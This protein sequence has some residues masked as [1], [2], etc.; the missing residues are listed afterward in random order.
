MSAPISCVR[1]RSAAAL[2]L[3]ILMPWSLYADTLLD[4][5]R[6]AQQRDPGYRVAMYALQAARERLL[7]ARAALLPMVSLNGSAGH[8]IGPTSIGGAE[9]VNRSVRNHGWNLQLTQPLWRAVNQI[10]LDQS[11]LQELLAEEQFQLAEQDLILRT[12]QAYFDLLVAQEAK[13]VAQMQIGA[14]ELQRSLAR[15]NFEIGAGTITDV[16][17]AESRLDL[18][19]AQAV[20]ADG[21]VQNKHAELERILGGGHVAPVGL[22]ADTWSQ[23]LQPESV[24]PWIDSARDQS[25]QVRIAEASLKVADREIAKSQAAHSPTLDLTATYGAN[26]SSG[27][28][29]SPLDV[30]VRAR[31]RQVG[32]NFS[33]P[34]YTG[35]GMQ[36]RVREAIALKD[37]ASEEL[38]AAR[39]L[40]TAQAR[41]AFTGVVNG[42]AQMQALASAIASS[43][44][45][46]D[47]N[48]VGYR[49]GTRINID[50]LNA[51]QQLYTAQRDWY[52]V[53][54]DILL[55]GLRL[56]ASNATLSEDDLSAINNLLDTGQF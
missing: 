32:L 1:P 40:A 14:M 47:A 18:A 39:R 21:E 45:S 46:L 53:R 52:K 42:T 49:I 3:L 23:S 12:A 10:A 16:H 55:Q 36:A 54:A 35:G 19:R 31:S 22:R 13:R 15:R 29:T 30:A 8:Q 11:G 20:A 51:E 27:S 17:E 37:R 24:Q 2:L 34:L 25:I 26:Y 38:E 28:I 41:Q 48:K 50:V 9:S 56:K 5:Y 43:K 6:R 44:S 4:V 7:Q 33:V